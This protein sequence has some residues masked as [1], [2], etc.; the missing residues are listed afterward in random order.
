MNVASENGGRNFLRV[1]GLF[2]G[3]IIAII[4]VTVTYYSYI[5]PAQLREAYFSRKQ[6]LRDF[7]G[8]LLNEITVNPSITTAEFIAR[9]PEFEILAITESEA[10]QI[11]KAV[12]LCDL[13]ANAEP[14]TPVLIEFYAKPIGS[15]GEKENV[16]CFIVTP[17][18]SGVIW[19]AVKKSDVSL[20]FE[21]AKGKP[22]QF[23][24]F[25]DL[26]SSMGKHGGNW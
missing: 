25:L 2:C 11:G 19:C 23:R 5:V 15:P 1:S 18:Y 7:S 3:S 10:P 20:L 17:R 6:K 4:C 24:E 21:S 22:K 9:N 14:G 12:I 16:N 13:Y 8:R 26:Y